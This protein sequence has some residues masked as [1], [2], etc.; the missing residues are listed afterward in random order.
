MLTRQ[1]LFGV[2]AAVSNR[3]CSMVMYLRWRGVD[4]VGS[5]YH[6]CI[7]VRSHE[8]QECEEFSRAH[9]CPKPRGGEPLLF[10][11]LVWGR[12]RSTLTL[13]IDWAEG[14]RNIVLVH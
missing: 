12:L 4:I 3:G 9:M 7:V 2:A 8:S 10:A 13:G 1:I 11:W 6:F 14:C 5:L